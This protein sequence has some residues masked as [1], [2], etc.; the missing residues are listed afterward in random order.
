MFFIIADALL[1]QNPLQLL[2]LKPFAAGI[3]FQVA[4]DEP[5]NLDRVVRQGSDPG[6]G[7]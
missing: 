5:V 4:F 2:L 7:R 3:Y 6:G 1:F